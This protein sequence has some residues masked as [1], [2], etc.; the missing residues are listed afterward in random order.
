VL[1]VAHDTDDTEVASHGSVAADQL[2]PTSGVTRTSP[3]CPVPLPAY[4][5]ATHVVPKGHVKESKVSPASAGAACVV[6]VCPSSVET[7]S[8][9]S[10][11]ARQD[12]AAVHATAPSRGVPTAI[13]L[14]DHAAVGVPL[15]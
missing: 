6:Q 13:A 3:R 11:T 12:P 4:P 2:V 10:P 1:E 7:A 9:P 15:V 14:A 8:N 5:P